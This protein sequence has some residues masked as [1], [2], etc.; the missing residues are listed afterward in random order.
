MRE[1]IC[2]ALVT[3]SSIHAITWRVLKHFKRDA[4]YFK[5]LCQRLLVHPIF[6]TFA[7]IFL[8]MFCGAYSH[9]RLLRQT[10][11]PFTQIRWRGPRIWAS[12]RMWEQKS[13]AYASTSALLASPSATS[14]W[15]QLVLQNEAPLLF[16]AHV[17]I[18][19]CA[20]TRLYAGFI[21]FGDMQEKPS[22]CVWARR[23]T[24]LPVVLVGP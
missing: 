10:S 20:R 17:C 11:E 24:S 9:E 21:L 22:T 23:G 4:R 18:S 15:L 2:T 5:H 6:K 8:S 7:S 1:H 3:L 19:V 16:G 13:T 14:V 12:W